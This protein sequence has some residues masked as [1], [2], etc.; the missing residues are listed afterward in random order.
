[1]LKKGLSGAFLAC[2]SCT[3][4]SSAVSSREKASRQKR[5][6]RGDTG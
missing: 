3:L 2:M 1:M 6:L 5:A 4:S